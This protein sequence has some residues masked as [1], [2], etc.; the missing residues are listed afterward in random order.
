MV[1][2]SPFSWE[3]ILFIASLTI[4]LHQSQ[5]AIKGDTGHIHPLHLGL[6][7]DNDGALHRSGTDL[8]TGIIC[9]LDDLLTHLLH[10]DHLPYIV[11]RLEN[12]TTFGTGWEELF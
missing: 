4:A 8:D 12:N 9:D 11:S 3:T 7:V 10:I 2:T 1:Q 5:D 6:A